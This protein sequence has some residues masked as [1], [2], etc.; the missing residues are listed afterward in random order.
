M[1]RTTALTSLGVRFAK[2]WQL[3]NEKSRQGLLGEPSR[4]GVKGKRQK[5]KIG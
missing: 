5:A 3:H 2:R 1:R 4:W